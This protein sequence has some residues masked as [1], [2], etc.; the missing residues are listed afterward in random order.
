MSAKRFRIAFSFAG[1]KRDFVAQVAAI[2]AQRFTKAAILYDKFHEAEFARYD[3][4]VYLPGL[5][6]DQ[7]DLV[8]AVLCKDYDVKLWSGWEWMAIHS[9]L[10]KNEG[11]KIML[12]RFDHAHVDGLF[13]NAGFVEL[14]DKTS[15]Q[16]ATLIL[17]R[18]ALNEGRPKDHYTKPASAS[19]PVLKTSTPNNLPRLDPS[20]GRLG[21]S[22]R[23]VPPFVSPGESS[24]TPLGTIPT[25]T[26]LNQLP[27]PPQDFTGRTTELEELLAAVTQRGVTICGLYGMGGIGKTTLALRLDEHL[28]PRY[29]DAQIYIDLKGIGTAPMSAAEAMAYV[30]SAYH[31]TEPLP[32]NEAA[33]RGRYQA[34]L[35]GQRALLLMDNAASREH[36][37][38][39]IPPASC[40]FLVTSR[41]Y[42]TLPGLF[43]KR[44]DPL[45][46][47]D[48]RTLVLTIAPR[49][50]EYADT[51]AQLCGYLPY[52]LR[53][54][55]RTLAEHIDLSPHT[56]VQRLTDT[57]Q[58]LGLIDMLLRVSFER[59]SPEVQQQ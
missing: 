41:E 11:A 8:V 45:P 1:E 3:L 33:L 46:P 9:Q 35:H 27:P 30:I 2:L 15:E 32:T 49:L 23:E 24:I 22:Q 44:L 28:T 13:E 54:A 10:N 6:C 39:L 21:A 51:L 5:Y 52:A 40:L 37:E 56:Y 14:D 26:I 42:F 29:P 12:C 36:M 55:V 4:G 57:L 20:Q 17:E 34:S 16:A 59:L 19:P 58:R 18:L 50:G 43:A 25:G 7:S 48:A 38:P 47:P 31:P 53:V